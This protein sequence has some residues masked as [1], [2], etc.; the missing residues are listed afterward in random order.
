MDARPDPALVGM[1][2]VTGPSR[3]RRM[4]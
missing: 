2:Q 4:R 1:L 3:N